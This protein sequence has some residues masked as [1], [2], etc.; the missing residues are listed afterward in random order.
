L[1]TQACLDLDL[2]RVVVAVAAVVAVAKSSHHA[3]DVVC[4]LVVAVA[5]KI[6]A[7]SA[8]IMI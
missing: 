7:N 6:A 3:V 8:K 5:R 1:A 2:D 4:H